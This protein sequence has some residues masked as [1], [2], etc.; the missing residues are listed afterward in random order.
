MYRFLFHR[1]RT[2][3]IYNRVEIQ[4]AFTT[5]KSLYH[6]YVD[7]I[8][9][10]IQNMG[11]LQPT[12]NEIM[13]DIDLTNK[14]CL[15]TG[16][17]SGIGQEMTRCLSSKN[18][19]VIMAC[20]NTYAA[21][22]VARTVCKRTDR[23]KVY[24]INLSSLSSV[25]KCSDEILRD[26]PKLDIVI[27]NAAVFG[28]PW[29]LTEDSFETTF[30][31]NYLS[32]AYL[33]MNIEKILAPDARVIIVSS[34]SHRHVNWPFFHKLSPTKEMVSLPKHEYTSI[35]AYNISK[36]CGIFFMHYLGYRWL[37]TGKLVF[38]A[39]PGTFVKTRLCTNW[40]PYET[41][42]NIM[43][44]FSKT[45][46]Q[47]ASTPLYCAVAPELN[48]MTD[49]YYKNLQR[50]DESELAQDLHLSF[51]FYDLTREL[52]LEQAISRDSVTVLEEKAEE[53]PQQAKETID[54]STLVAN[55]SG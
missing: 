26:I 17:N 6:N 50:C 10:I 13:K 1:C 51:R 21:D 30:Q 45:I 39:N 4:Y 41:L 42:Y 19:T 18:C 34:D 29:T 2:S 3:Y 28:L 40:W 20:R 33:L 37:N 8:R 23:L 31:V 48:G 35:K 44:P 32:H 27:L 5:T 24:E 16:A 54:D 36:L 55:Y 25:K 49:Q 52:L 11:I 15:I 14:T 38:C 43:K 7:F 12:S 9:E 47:A 46:S 53:Y 22:I